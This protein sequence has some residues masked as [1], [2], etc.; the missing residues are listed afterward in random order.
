M[1]GKRLRV[2]S[3]APDWNRFPGSGPLQAWARELR[4]ACSSTDAAA[5]PWE[6]AG[7]AAIV[8]SND[9]TSCNA[10]LRRMAADAGMRFISI[11]A[12]DVVGLV[13][14]TQFDVDGPDECDPEP[15]V[16]WRRSAPLLVHLERG[17]WMQAKSENEDEGVVALMLRFQKRL[18]SW[19]G[20]FDPEHPVVIVT[21][22]DDVPAMVESLRQ[23]GLFDRFLRLPSQTMEAQ[24]HDFIERIGRAHCAESVT[25]TP[26]K[27]GKL[28]REMYEEERRVGL[29][30]L[31]LRRLIVREE[32]KLEFIDL[33]NVSERGFAEA[34]MPPTE[35]EGVRRQFAYHEAGHAV[36]AVIDSGGHNVPEYSSI[37]PSAHFNG[38]VVQSYS[39]ML[40]AGD[41]FT[42]ADLRHKVRISLAGRAAEELVYGAE[43]VSSGASEDLKTATER[44]GIAF[45]LW[46]FAPSM[47]KDGQ[48]GSNLAVVDSDGETLSEA[49]RAH[50]EGLVREF[51]AAE[52]RAVKAMLTAHRPLLD[53]VADRLMVDPIVDQ[54]TLAE[55]VRAHVPALEAA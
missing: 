3:D 38:V 28:V 11:A 24:G 25:R 48:A 29:A 33:V 55:L 20:E 15:P 9:V 30:V 32:R 39:Y 44:S 21:S 22:A 12:D 54:E 37:V 4:Q 41:L 6:L 5:D 40:E 16:E 45:A 36:V 35:A 50:V 46:G 27:V 23:V 17:R 19:I 1:R 42:Y 34:E 2:P 7:H 49:S 51:L 52:Y 26:G 31:R 10:V 8:V 47:E 43:R 13:P 18:A 14:V 53:A